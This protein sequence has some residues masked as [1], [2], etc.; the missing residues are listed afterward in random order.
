MTKLLTFVEIDT[1]FCSLTYGSSP[2]TAAIPTTG[3]DRCYN[4]RSI[5]ADCQDPANFAASTKTLR[6]TMDSGH[7]PTDIAAR[8]TLVSCDISPGVIKP[9][10]SIGERTTATLVFKNHRTGDADTDN[11]F[12]QRS[13]VPWEQGTYWGKFIARNSYIEGQPIRIYKGHVGQELA[14]ME[15]YN[16]FID[17]ID[18]P[19][20]NGK[21]TVRCVDVFR[22]LDDKEAQAPLASPGRLSAALTVGATSATLT[23]SG[24]GNSDYP[25]SGKVKIGKE[26]CSFTR[27]GDLLTLTR[28]QHGTTA[29]AHDAD[30]TVQLCLEYA[31]QT[32]SDIIDDLIDN[33]TEIDSS[34]VPKGDWDAE[35]ANFNS[36]TL[37]SELITKPTALKDLINQLVQQ[38]GLVLYPDPTKGKII[39]QVLRP[40]TTSARAID[41][42]QIL[43]GGVKAKVLEIKRIDQVW[44]LYNKADKVAD[45]KESKAYISQLATID[46]D[47]IYLNRAIK[48][49]NANWIPPG[50]LS[51][52]QT[53]NN[54]LL[55]RFLH[56]PRRFTFVLDHLNGVDLGEPFNL[57]TSAHEAPDGSLLT[58]P[59][60]VVSVKR[61][62]GAIQ[63]TAEETRFD[64]ILIDDS[65]KIVV[66][67]Y[68]AR[69]VNLRDAFDSI[70]SSTTGTTSVHFE[71]SSGVVIGS[72]DTTLPGLDVGSWPGGITLTL[73]N[74]GF[75]VGRG[76]N[77]ENL[78]PSPDIPAQDG[79]DAFYTRQAISVDNTN[80]V[81]GGGGGGG[82][83]GSPPYSGGGAGGGAGDAPGLAADGNDGTL[84]SGGAG[85][86]SGNGDGGD[87]GQPG[88]YG[89][90]GAGGNAVDG[91]SYVTWT[92]AGDIRG[93]QVN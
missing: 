92:A 42:D 54:R 65:H 31:S 20:T 57:I 89:G 34:W 51:V 74:N 63:V 60:R 39:L 41:D 43:E 24:I 66:F 53:L 88:Q 71:V 83:H 82:G 76:G 84:E 11:Y 21:V 37:Y 68:N 45:Y 7:M 8:P 27:S 22:F 47:S 85:W 32:A 77:G 10:E 55:S 25:A 38:V 2:C 56:P 72:N 3:A 19:D 26:I 70:Y 86:F 50:G 15:T 17:A 18:G 29:E 93:A 75:I 36:G 58:V 16:L 46:S 79:G 49:V 81:I 62:D 33:Y 78:Q 64:E 14:D 90:A 23:P 28:A 48:K 1:N 9:G 91:D 87:L 80:G 35:I 30:I 5:H 67:D 59:C 61:L 13:Y 69:N 6:Y 40:I 73:A 12:D 52:A 44:S 4:T